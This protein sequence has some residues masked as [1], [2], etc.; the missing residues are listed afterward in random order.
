MDHRNW[1]GVQICHNVRTVPFFSYTVKSL[2]RS[3]ELG[4]LTVSLTVNH[5]AQKLGPLHIYN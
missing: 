4:L 2:K 1:G 3:E 5:T